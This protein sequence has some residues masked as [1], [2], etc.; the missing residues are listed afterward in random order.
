M[1]GL[2]QSL[3]EYDIVVVKDRLG[4]YAYQAVKAKWKNRFRLAVWLDNLTTFP[5]ED[6]KQMRTIRNEVTNAA[7]VFL[8]QTEAAKTTLLLEGIEA[9]R[10]EYFAPWV[11]K[12]VVRNKKNRAKALETIGLPEGSFVIAHI[13]QI[14]WEEGLSDLTT[15][16]KLAIDQNPSLARQLKLVFCGIGSFMSQLRETLIALKIDD[17][18]M[19]IAP[20]RQAFETVLAAAD[21]IFLGS[22]PARDRI[23][24]EPYRLVSAMTN[25]LPVLANRSPLIEEFCGKHRID[26]CFG[27]PQSIADAI[28][29][30]SENAALKND[31]VKKN[32]STIAT[33]FGKDKIVK[34]MHVVFKKLA[35]KTPTLDSSSI[36]NQVREAE[37]LVSSKQ[38]LKAIDAIE[39]VFQVKEIPLHHSANLYRLIGDCFAKLGDNDGAKN[40]Y[41][42]AIEQDPYSAR[43]YI[44]LGTV[45]LVKQSHDIAVLHFQKAVSLAPDDEMANLGLGLA[46]Q[47]MDEMEEATQ[48]IPQQSTRLFV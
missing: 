46:F 13:G 19:F 22:T 5:A 26:F 25:E 2:E 37:A 33:K 40:A 18:A 6:V 43:A 34:Q 14:E 30:L 24:G 45:G 31:I 23:E 41:I 12:T 15:G 48:K 8:V 16:I 32:A 39:S 27:S 38:Y 29:K 42:K 9:A 44:G 47:G 11:E 7:D 3:A 35:K 17:R 4:L 36:D 21:C 20:T 28:Y 1:P 10:I